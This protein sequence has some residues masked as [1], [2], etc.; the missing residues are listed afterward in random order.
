M[1]ADNVFY[2]YLSSKEPRHPTTSDE[3]PIRTAFWALE[4]TYLCICICISDRCLC[5]ISMKASRARRCLVRN[6]LTTVIAGPGRQC[7]FHMPLTGLFKREARSFEQFLILAPSYNCKFSCMCN[8]KYLNGFI[9]PSMLL[10]YA[11]DQPFQERQEAS[12]C[13]LQERSFLGKHVHRAQ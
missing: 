6:E 8:R 2:Y 13:H 4:E 7:Y 5:A 9:W 12:E 10:S 1:F 11:T 3:S